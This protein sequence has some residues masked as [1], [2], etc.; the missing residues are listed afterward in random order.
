MV[1]QVAMILTNRRARR[2]QRQVS[3]RTGEQER[4][5][6]ARRR[7]PRNS[8]VSCGSNALTAV[9]LSHSKGADEAFEISSRIAKQGCQTNHF[10][11]NERQIGK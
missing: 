7:G 10:G 4:A 1:G 3:R 5:A 6:A 2:P 8:N 9:R 11:D